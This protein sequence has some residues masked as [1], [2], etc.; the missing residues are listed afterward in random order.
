MFNAL[1]D[2]IFFTYYLVF[3]RIEL[4]KKYI[5]LNKK[6]VFRICSI[7]LLLISHFNTLI[8][9]NKV[10]LKNKR[11]ASLLLVLGFYYYSR[12]V[13]FNIS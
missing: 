13:L 8:I 2:F 1:W 12:V 9:C 11:Y 3:F 5:I 7:I 4:N 6:S 10:I